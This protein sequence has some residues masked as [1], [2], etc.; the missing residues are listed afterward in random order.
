MISYL[1]DPWLLFFIV[2]WYPKSINNITS[3][4]ICNQI[5]RWQ[6]FHSLPH[7]S[8]ALYHCETDLVITSL[9]SRKKYEL[10]Q[11]YSFLVVTSYIIW[12]H[13][14]LNS[15][16]NCR[17]KFPTQELLCMLYTERV[18]C[19]RCCLWQSA[20]SRSRAR[21]VAT[22]EGSG[23]GGAQEVPVPRICRKKDPQLSSVEVHGSSTANFSIKSQCFKVPFIPATEK[24]T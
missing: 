15:S 7:S 17:K 18:C 10:W 5:P 22:L 16:R 6:T 14:S 4:N 12:F 24:R 21:I 19:G 23:G 1:K 20:A 11:K 3:S 13:I 2:G 8:I 9:K